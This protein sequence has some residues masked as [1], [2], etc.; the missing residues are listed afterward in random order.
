MYPREV[1]FRI[2]GQESGCSLNKA[3]ILAR[4]LTSVQTTVTTKM[5]FTPLRY[6]HTA[7]L[8][9][10]YDNMNFIYLYKYF[11]DTLNHSALSVMHVDNGEKIE[12][13]DARTRVEDGQNLWLRLNIRGRESRFQWSAD[14]E[15]YTDIGPV[16]DTSLFS[17]EYSSFGEFTGAFVGITCGDRLLHR[18]TADFDFFHYEAD[19]TASVE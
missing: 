15:T 19:E 5:D 16:F 17:D 14:G 1:S 4:K 2:R 13:S 10:Y 8:I 9:L 6:Q 11:S 12:F 7:G 18:Q 3:S